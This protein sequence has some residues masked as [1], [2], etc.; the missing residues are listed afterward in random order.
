MND[1]PTNTWVNKRNPVEDWEAKKEFL[2]DFFE[3][4]PAIRKTIFAQEAGI[5][6]VTLNAVL[7][8]P[9]YKISMWFW[10]RVFKVVRFYG[11]FPNLTSG[12]SK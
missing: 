9:E 3:K 10:K 7:Y 1:I 6:C 5:S 12:P 11:G 8:D 4:R 2:K